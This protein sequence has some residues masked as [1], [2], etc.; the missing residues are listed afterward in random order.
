MCCMIS[1]L[2]RNVPRLCWSHNGRQYQA[3][4]KYSPIHY[5]STAKYCQA[6]LKYLLPLL[7]VA[8]YCT[9]VQ[10]QSLLGTAVAESNGA[11][12][13]KKHCKAGT[14]WS[15]K[16]TYKS[17]KD[18][19][20]KSASQRQALLWQKLKQCWWST[21]LAS[22]TTKNTN[23]QIHKYTQTQKYKRCRRA[24]EVWRE[25]KHYAGCKAHHNQ[26]HPVTRR[27]SDWIFVT[28]SDQIP[29]ICEQQWPTSKYWI[30]VNFLLTAAKDTGGKLHLVWR[31]QSSHRQVPHHLLPNGI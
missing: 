24:R 4:F 19:S 21:V 8:K 15:P 20:G 23:K 14:S 18:I 1:V 9:V 29:N 30:A 22:K 28:N 2:C 6:L 11:E 27:S 5:T 26:L 17:T 3:L 7:S 25:R 13:L 12:S 10:V 31:L 16:S